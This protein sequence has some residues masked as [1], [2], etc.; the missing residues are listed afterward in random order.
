MITKKRLLTLMVLALAG[1]WGL[2]LGAQQPTAPLVAAVPAGSTGAVAEDDSDEDN[3]PAFAPFINRLKVA[4]KEPQVRL[5]WQDIANFTG[6][7]CIYR[8]TEEITADNI[9][10]AELVNEISQGEQFF[11]DIPPKTGSYYYAVL[12][13]QAGGPIYQIFIPF[14]NKTLSPI[15]ITVA[16]KSEDLA[17]E[18]SAFQAAVVAQSIEVNLSSSRNT[19]PIAVFRGT[20]PL[21]SNDDILKAV[22][23]WT[24]TGRLVKVQD[25]AVPGVPYYYAAVDVEAFQKGS[26]ALAVG[27]NT[28]ADPIEI[29]LG[30]RS[31]T[32][33]GLSNLKPF[34][35]MPLPIL[36]LPD[37]GGDKLALE[38]TNQFSVNQTLDAVTRAKIAT[39]TAGIKGGQAGKKSSEILPSDRL[40]IEGRAL[41]NFS[42]ES[43]ALIE[44]LVK[45]FTRTNWDESVRQLN[46]LLT[47]PL[48][49]NVQYKAHFYLAQ[50][51]YLNGHYK[52]ALM[53]FLF[54]QD[55]LPEYAQPWIDNTLERSRDW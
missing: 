24:G 27:K 48:S 40:Q 10:K 53:E 16:P 1:F 35:V 49:K 6:S 11:T 28:L 32:I 52:E 34:R 20:G 5:T 14:R 29:P 15:T 50:A 55:E 46:N 25:F 9:A 33:S 7:Y 42:G 41:K 18:I 13:K 4:I 23:I 45:D 2:G 54:V 37:L 12:A 38:G 47:L 8:H 3:T 43:K 26:W 30:T 19:R 39:L 31:T 36:T 44:I 51:Y 21:T 17:S 22:Q